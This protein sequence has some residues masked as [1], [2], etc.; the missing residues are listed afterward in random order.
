MKHNRFT[1]PFRSWEAKK[2]PDGDHPH[3]F[4]IPR[5]HHYGLFPTSQ[6][7]WT[8]HS[9][10]DFSFALHENCLYDFR[11]EGRPH[12]HHEAINKV[13]GLS[14]GPHKWNSV[15]IGWRRAFEGD[16]LLEA[17]DLFL[18]S[19]LRT[20]RTSYP[21]FR[22]EPGEV[23]RG[24]IYFDQ[25]GYGIVF[26]ER[27]WESHY[28]FSTRLRWGFV[29]YPFFGGRLPAPQDMSME[30]QFQLQPGPVSRIVPYSLAY[31]S[32]PLL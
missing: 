22:I 24:Q 9:C 5:G 30:I 14:R 2:H 13:V 3:R 11:Q 19:Y 6:P 4:Q 17:F 16:Q 27:G 20:K 28:P 18:Y 29:L 25:R 1:V 21:L 31:G 23:I 32:E 12:S 26:P 10:L 15:R 7:F 8:R